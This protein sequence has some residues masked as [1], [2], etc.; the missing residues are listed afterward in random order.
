MVPRAASQSHYLAAPT[1]H[2]LAAADPMATCRL[3][4]K[5]AVSPPADGFRSTPISRHS[6]GRSACLK[7]ATNGHSLGQKAKN[8]CET[9]NR[10]GELAGELRNR[11]VA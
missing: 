6:Q 8:K 2:R 4:V 7:R 3:W 1:S 5:S 11:R 10:A 9:K